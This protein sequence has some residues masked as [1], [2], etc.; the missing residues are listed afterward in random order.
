MPPTKKIDFSKPQVMGIVNVT[1]DS[2]SDG[3]RYLDEGSLVTHLKALTA[4]G[5][6][7][8]DIGGE[9]TRPGAQP[10]SLEEECRRVLP[11]IR[12]AQQHSHLPISIDT[13][14][15]QVMSAALA[16]GASMVNDV[17]ALTRPN[18]LAVVADYQVP[19]CLMHMQ[20]N[21]LT[22]QQSPFYQDVIQAIRHFFEERI[23][24]CLAAG[25][26]ARNIIL[27]PGFGF[28]KTVAHNLRL[29]RDLPLLANLGF[30]ILIGVSRK[31]TIGKVLQRN[32]EERLY[33]GLALTSLALANGASI[34]RTHDVAATV[35]VLRMTEAVLN[36]EEW[37]N[38]CT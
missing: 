8:L 33:G 18:A 22:M 20:G 26:Q 9:S 34:I 28:G 27:D 35:D 37:E 38:D 6:R 31:S 17:C 14:K 11:A 16:A 2:F 13:S 19:V 23:E 3:G 4:S 1:P 12:L 21:P 25:I 36:P 30:R 29:V 7:L 5:C 10:V 15:A 24:A 32:V